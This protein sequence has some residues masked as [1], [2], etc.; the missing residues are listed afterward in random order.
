VI[1][2]IFWKSWKAA[3]LCFIQKTRL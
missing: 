2:L 1:S 3:S